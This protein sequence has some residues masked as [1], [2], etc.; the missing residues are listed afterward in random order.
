MIRLAVPAD[1]DAIGTMHAA[2][3]TETYAGLVP[4]ELL[5][6][7]GDP[8]RRRAAWARILGEPLMPENVFLAEEGGWVLGFASV[9]PVRDPALGTEGELTSI[10]L[11]R[12]AQGQGLGTALLGHALAR[13]RAAGLRSAGAWALET[14]RPA[15]RF[16]AARGARP[17]PRRIEHRGSH[18]LPEAGW[19]WPDL[20]AQP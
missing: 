14:N 1:A 5:A 9:A 4:D 15:A 11:L 12:R 19:I 6:E 13:L 2:A 16:Y 20:G 10:Y 18:R 8:A 3:W 17:G 7:H